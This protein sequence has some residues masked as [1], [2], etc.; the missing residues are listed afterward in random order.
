M[1]PRCSRPTPRPERR[2]RTSC[3]APTR[4]SQLLEACSGDASHSPTSRSLTD[5]RADPGRRPSSSS[6]AVSSRSRSRRRHWSTVEG[7][8]VDDGADRSPLPAWTS[9]GVAQEAMARWSGRRSS[10]RSPGDQD[11]RSAGARRLAE[12]LPRPGRGRG[13]P[14]RGRAARA[15]RRARDDPA[16]RRARDGAAGMGKLVFLDLVD[17]SG[18]IQVICDV[19][20]T[21][22]IDVHLGDVIGVTGRPAKSRRGEPSVLAESVEVLSRNT[23]PLPDTF[24]GLT[25]VELRYRKSYL[26][27]LMNEESRDVVPHP[28]EGRHGDPARARRVGLRRGRD[29]G[30]A[31]ALRRRLRAAVHRPITTSSTRTSTCASRPSSTSSG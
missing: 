27:L 9:A 31:A 2:R 10:R 14:G 18:R 29:A 16:A 19:A 5:C 1:A 22:E 7:A 3:R 11:V 30:P 23:Q 8:R 13:G 17:R 25:D 6:S 28:R 4:P 26:D 21:G 24:H 15:R 12:A 20:V